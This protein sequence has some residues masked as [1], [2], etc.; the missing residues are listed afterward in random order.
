MDGMRVT[1]AFMGICFHLAIFYTV[2]PQSLQIISE[3]DYSKGFFW[4]TQVLQLF[5]M[6]S[7]FLMAGFFA[8][9][10]LTKVDFQTF[11]KKRIVNLYLINIVPLVFVVTTLTSYLIQLKIGSFGPLSPR[12]WHSLLF[13]LHLWFLVVLFICYYIYGFLLKKSDCI[14]FFQNKV[15]PMHLLLLGFI[16]LCWAFLAKIFPVLWAQNIAIDSVYRI[17]IYFPY[18]MCGAVSYLNKNVAES[19]MK[20]SFIRVAASLLCVFAYLYIINQ[21]Y[22]LVDAR[23]NAALTFKLV[24]YLAKGFASLGSVY[25]VFLVSSKIFKNDGKILQYL[26]KRSYTVYLLHYPL[27]LIIGYLFNILK[28]NSWFE[29]VVSV[30]SVYIITLLMHDVLMKLIKSKVLQDMKAINTND[31]SS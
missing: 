22:G 13:L 29:Y 21:Q 20:H 16:Y 24:T 6:D 27:C 5:R 2:D 10:S 25:L 19:F 26:S 30:F 3:P 31:T 11:F 12:F 18:F 28:L 9:M 8:A 17:F 15:R 7:F 14:N 4:I 1:F 23:K